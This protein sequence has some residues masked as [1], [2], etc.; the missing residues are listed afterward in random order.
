[1]PSPA[2]T[3]APQLADAAGVAPLSRAAPGRAARPAAGLPPHRQR[4][5]VLRRPSGL[6][7]LGA[8]RRAHAGG[9][10][11][12]LSLYLG[13]SDPGFT[14]RVYTHLLPNSEDRTRRAIDAAFG[15]GLENR[16]GLATA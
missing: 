15:H 8:S 13:H 4:S 11:K 3:D 16:D 12:A 1:M 14:L 7:A 9:S 6:P 2:T 5:V 10:I